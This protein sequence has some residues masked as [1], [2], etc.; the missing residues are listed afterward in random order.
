MLSGLVTD[1]TDDYCFAFYVFSFTFQSI[2]TNFVSATLMLLRVYAL[3]GRDKRVV[4]ILSVLLV[5]ELGLS[6]AVSVVSCIYARE[7]ITY[8][9]FL[10]TCTMAVHV[11]WVWVVFLFMSFFDIAV[12]LL[13]LWKTWQ[14]V[15]VSQ[16]R[17]SLLTALL[18]DGV[19]Y[20]LIMLGVE[21]V[22]IFTF[23][24]FSSTF[25]LVALNIAW[26]LNT[27]MVSR[28]YLNLRKTARPQDWTDMTAFKTPGPSPIRYLSTQL[29]AR[30]EEDSVEGDS[31]H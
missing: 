25:F 28:I 31:W 19:W 13:V 5:A 3:Y 21:F 7:Q 11:P 2:C 17:T 24:I 9:A 15:R 16:V 26:C 30:S 10:G 29:G 14:H 4:A 23:A 18:V 8:V 1:A 20:F 22:N 6:V 27:M 12:F